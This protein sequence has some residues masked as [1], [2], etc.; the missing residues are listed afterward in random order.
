[1]EINN[2]KCSLEEHKEIPAITYCEQCKQYMCSNCEKYH[3]DVLEKHHSFLVGDMTR[4]QFTGFC[5]EE[6][7]NNELEYFCKNHNKLCCI[8]CITKIKGEGKG[9]HNDCDICFIKDIKDEKKNKLKENIQYLENLSNTITQSINELKIINEN[10]NKNKEDLKIRIQKLFT[11][12]RNALN[13]REDQ[14]LLKVTQIYEK[15][16]FNKD[17]F[18]ENEKLPE[19]IKISLEKWKNIDRKWDNK[20]IKLN[21][22]INSCINIENNINDIHKINENVKKYNITKN[23][24]ID[25]FPEEYEIN[26]FLEKIKKFGDIYYNDFKYK[27]KKCPPNIGENRRYII[28][29]E[30]ENIFTKIGA[31]CQFIGAICEDKLEKSKEHKWKINILNS[32]NKVIMVGVAS[33]DF[34]I[35][36]SSY[37]TCGW[38]F[39]CY[40]STLYSGE[41]HNYNNKKTNLGKVK[42]EIEIIMDMNKGDL[43][44]II[45]NEDKGES[46]SGI[47]LDKPLAPVVLLYDKSDSIEIIEC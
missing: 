31:S 17:L 35:N 39:Y 23:I 9:Q 12:I 3:K 10:I 19:Q 45:N 18:K 15:I 44:F 27:L 38:Y 29:G 32:K 6:R 28:T 11:K 16:Y 5:K 36:S 22:L 25:F 13:K 4:E 47:P 21:S 24:K 37:N 26:K 34:N 40:N 14:L 1:M 46:F 20:N 8:A 30:K 2:K 43:K 41:P 33:N 42:D 7:H